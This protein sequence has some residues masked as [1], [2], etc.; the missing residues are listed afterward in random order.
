MNEALKDVIYCNISNFNTNK[1]ITIPFKLAPDYSKFMLAYQLYKTAYLKD[2][3]IC[4]WF[5]DIYDILE[6]NYNDNFSD[7]KDVDGTNVYCLPFGWDGTKM[8]VTFH[9][10]YVTTDPHIDITNDMPFD[11]PYYTINGKHYINSHC[12]LDHD[13]TVKSIIENIFVKLSRDI[14]EYDV[15]EYFKVA[16]AIDKSGDFEILGYTITFG[17]YKTL[18]EFFENQSSWKGREND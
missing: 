3:T 8:S 17:V 16:N 7:W 18:N 10:R 6:E 2:P 11:M 1:C 4:C 14:K 5:G 12:L 15:H 9:N 13:E